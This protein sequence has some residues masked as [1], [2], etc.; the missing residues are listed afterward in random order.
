MRRQ[1][2]IVWFGIFLAWALFRAN[3]VLSEWVDELLVKP[4]IF[5]LPV[6]GVIIFREKKSLCSLG[7]CPSPKDFLLDLYIGVV[8][9]IIFALEG[10]FSNYL[11]HGTFSFAPIL[12]AKTAGG[13]I[14]FLLLNLSTSIWEEILGRGYLF[15]RLYEVTDKLAHSAF[16]A[17]FLFLLLH[18][19]I[20]FTRLHL[21]GSTLIIYICTTILL[22]ITNCYLLSIRKSLTLPILI[23]TFWNMTVALFL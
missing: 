16:T 12:A 22:G 21:K 6:M 3:F 11:K 19:P 15:K 14:Y 10:L 9:G 20:I 5:V 2:F 8:I 23:H 18:I 13:M 1:V 4:A 17:S 7:I